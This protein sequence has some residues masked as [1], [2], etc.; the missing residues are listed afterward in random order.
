MLARE[1]KTRRLALA[2]ALAV[3]LKRQNQSRIAPKVVSSSQS[4]NTYCRIS[5]SCLAPDSFASFLSH[6]DLDKDAQRRDLYRL[7]NTFAGTHV[8]SR[9]RYAEHFDK[10]WSE[11]FPKTTDVN[12]SNMAKIVIAN[13]AVWKGELSNN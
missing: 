1:G 9:V 11:V 12:C 4:T 2:L 6:A 3:V 7:G 13:K 8:F 10:I 5:H